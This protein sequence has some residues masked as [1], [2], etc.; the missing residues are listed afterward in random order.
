MVQ[1]AK[2]VPAPH[3]RPSPALV[4]A[5]TLRGSSAEHRGR[6]LGRAAAEPA[7]S[8]CR[9][10]YA[11]CEQLDGCCSRAR[12]QLQALAAKAI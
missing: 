4:L 1:R 5:S 11:R 12:V 9:D 6:Q 8:C 7:D 3:A 2:V 10:I